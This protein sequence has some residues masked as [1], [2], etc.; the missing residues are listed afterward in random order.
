M[1]AFFRRLLSLRI[2]GLD[3]QATETSFTVTLR[4]IQLFRTE[5]PT[6]VRA[7]RLPGQARDTM[8][9]TVHRVRHVITRVTRVT[10]T[11][12]QDQQ[13]RR[14]IITLSPA[15]WCVLITLDVFL[16]PLALAGLFILFWLAVI[17]LILYLTYETADC[18]AFNAAHMLDGPVETSLKLIWG[19][20]RSGQMFLLANT[21]AVNR[22]AN[23]PV[24]GGAEGSTSMAV[25]G[26][27]VGSTSMAVTG[28]TAGSTST[29]VAGPVAGQDRESEEV[30]LY[31]GR[32]QD[33]R[34]LPEP[35]FLSTPPATRRRRGD[36]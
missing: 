14:Q 27:A 4:N 13:Q 22:Q 31:E 7:A 18:I 2:P 25:T 33:E 32:A 23:T 24:T 19:L 5:I 9:T 11:T 1:F 28:P 26:G 16:L 30:I 3:L 29:A 15:A 36:K 20:A 6:I 21:M 35:G 34:Q 10:Q 17:W 12:Q 8:R